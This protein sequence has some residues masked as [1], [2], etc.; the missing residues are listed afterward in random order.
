M[1]IMQC[2]CHLNHLTKTLQMSQSSLDSWI[3]SSLLATLL[4]WP[5]ICS[6]WWSLSNFRSN[7]TGRR[8]YCGVH[9]QSW[10][11]STSTMS[12]R[13]CFTTGVCPPTKWHRPPQELW[14]ETLVSSTRMTTAGVLSGMRPLH[15]QSPR[16]KLHKERS[17]LPASVASSESSSVLVGS[18]HSSGPSSSLSA[19]LVCNTT[20][21]LEEDQSTTIKLR[22][23]RPSWRRI[24][25]LPRILP[26]ILTFLTP[27]RLWTCQE[28][29]WN[30]LD[31]Q[32]GV[33][34]LIAWP[35]ILKK[36]SNI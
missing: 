32:L 16:A 19:S 29:N 26:R 13:W 20:R 23:D 36:T 24:L 15:N 30:E 14:M 31:C 25:T 6:P 33:R 11:F 9:C 12:S 10:P 27:D 5:G 28:M 1:P 17:C 7:T 34:F 8:R 18:R 3:F 21:S 22:R 2:C 35:R 4:S